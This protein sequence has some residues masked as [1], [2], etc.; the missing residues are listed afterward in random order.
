VAM[1]AKFDPTGSRLS[2]A[3]ALGVAEAAGIAV[4]AQGAAYVAGQTFASDFP[5]V[6]PVQPTLRA[7]TGSG[8]GFVMKLNAPGTAPIYS[9]YLGGSGNDDATGIAI[10]SAGSAYVTGE[11]TS[12]DFL[13]VNAAQ[14]TIGS[15][16]CCL[17]DAF[18][19]KIGA[20]GAPPPPASDAGGAPGAP[21]LDASSLDSPDDAGFDG[22]VPAAHDPETPSDR[23]V[24]SGCGCQVVDEGRRTEGGAFGV[25]CALACLVR[26][27][28]SSRSP[29]RSRA[30]E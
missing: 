24:V 23:L 30:Q 26:Q 19:A 20:I 22:S 7:A 11:V 9:T 13:T 28:R 25:I 17:S 14:P 5:V 18:V 8:N 6:D 27:K 21:P 4:D 29:R 3:T 2:Y 1:V 15:L 16:Q 12:R 10:D